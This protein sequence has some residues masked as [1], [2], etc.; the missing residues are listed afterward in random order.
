MLLG[1]RHP[2]A[3]SGPGANSLVVG[4]F[5]VILSIGGGVL[6]VLVVVVHFVSKQNSR[7]FDL[8]RGKTRGAGQSLHG[9]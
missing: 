4:F 8:P 2:S 7:E 6:A 5:F 9:E 1:Q 3:S